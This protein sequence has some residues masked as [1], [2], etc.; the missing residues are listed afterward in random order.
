MTCFQYLFLPDKKHCTLSFLQAVFRGSK[1]VFMADKVIHLEIPQWNELSIAN[2]WAK[3]I[4]IKGFLDHM[5][6]DWNTSRKVSRKYFYCILCTLAKDWVMQLIQ[7][8]REKREENAQL[9]KL[10]P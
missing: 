9:R 6:D 5:P 8:C 7:E 1:R 3:A 4:L 2:I 10:K